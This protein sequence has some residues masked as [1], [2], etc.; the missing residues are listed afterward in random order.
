MDRLWLRTVCFLSFFYGHSR[1]VPDPSLP[2]QGAGFLMVLLVTTS[3]F[4]ETKLWLWP[5]AGPQPVL[6]ISLLQLRAPGGA[7]INIS[8][9][10]ILYHAP[11]MRHVSYQTMHPPHAM[12]RIRPC[13]RHTPCV[14]S[15]RAPATHH[16]SYQTVHPPHAMSYQTVI[17]FCTLGL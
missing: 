11:A 13:T 12:C 9:P 14:V 3:Q 10:V 2:G 6:S 15:D 7:A 5:H 16:V 1:W 8:D 17:P 4:L